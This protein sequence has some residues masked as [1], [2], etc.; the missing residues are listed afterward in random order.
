VTGVLASRT[1]LCL[2]LTAAAACG[3]TTRVPARVGA[4]SAPEGVLQP[5]TVADVRFMTGMIHHH[6][7]A[8]LIAGWAAS[9]GASAAVQRLSER[10]VV[11]QQDEIALM[12]EWLLDRGEPAPSGDPA[13]VHA[14]PLMP[15]ML[16]ADQM[17]A[18]TAARGREFDRLFLT[19]MIQH[20]E[21]ALTMVNELF[22]SF[23]AAQDEGVFRL[24]SDIFADQSAEIDRMQSMLEQV[25]SG[26]RP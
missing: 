5:Y 7:Q 2:F 26:G 15:G 19:L 12:R 18:L 11:A 16:S 14:A 6:A 3:G 20:H 23:G 1:V 9:R 24:A 13:H 22:A 10:I 8:V 4:A 25:S 17:A 21:G